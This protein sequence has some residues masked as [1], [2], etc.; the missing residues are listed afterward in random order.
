[1]RPLKKIREDLT[2]FIKTDIEGCEIKSKKE[3]K[4]MKFVGKIMF[5]N[6]RFMTGFITTWYPNIYVPELPWKEQDHAPAIS[7]LAHEWVHLNDR[8]RM[9]WLF[10]LLYI[11]PQCLTAFSVFAFWNLWFLLFLLFLLPIPSPGRA[12]AEFRGY[13]M[14]I[15]INYW[16]S[17]R[18]VDLKFPK[19]I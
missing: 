9:G 17:G 5:F 11:S 16:L 19:R 13:R 18:K 8:K 2:S 6:K 1:M 7:I 4:I 14:T 10:D 15:A 12:W 3:S